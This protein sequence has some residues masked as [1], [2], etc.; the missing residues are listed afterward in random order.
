MGKVLFGD[1]GNTG[2]VKKQGQWLSAQGGQ[3]RGCAQQR[4]RGGGVQ[5]REEFSSAQEQ[6]GDR[7]AKIKTAG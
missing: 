5:R 7:I 4:R 6:V 2:N 1:I 3:G